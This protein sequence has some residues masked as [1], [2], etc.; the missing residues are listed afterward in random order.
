M[1]EW[2]KNGNFKNDIVL[3]TRVRLARNIK[4]LP[5]PSKMTLQSEVDLLTSKAKKSFMNNSDFEFIDFSK[6]SNLEKW[7]LQER[8]LISSEFAKRK[9]SGLILSRDEK[10]SIMIMEEDHF[11]LQSILPGLDIEK[12][13]SLVDEMDNMLSKNADYAFSK[14]LGYIASCPTNLGTGM[15]VSVMLN[16]PALNIS[17]QMGSLIKDLETRGQTCRGA[18]GEGSS[19]LGDLFQISNEVTLG[20]SEKEI[21]DG[22]KSSVLDII[23]NEKEAEKALYQSNKGVVEDKVF[24]SLGT[25]KNARLISTN[26][27]TKCISYVNMGLSMGLLKNISHEKLYSLIINTRPASLAIDSGKVLPENIRDEK[28]AALVRNALA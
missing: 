3:S 22:V 18:F 16:L 11:R 19:P 6:I 17:G 28:R 13:Y 8:Y 23:K 4:G 5:F 15:R 20:Y 25:L 26:E 27:M 24:R 14:K 1:P 12:A 21:L 9:Y 10:L 7:V 2:M